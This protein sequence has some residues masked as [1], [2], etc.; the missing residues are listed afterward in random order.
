ML[1][2]VGTQEGFPFWEEKGRRWERGCVYWG[3]W[4]GAAIR[5]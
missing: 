5:M 2:F 3:K 1:G 4:E